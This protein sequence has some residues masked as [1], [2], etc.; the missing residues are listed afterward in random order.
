MKNHDFK[1]EILE[2]LRKLRSLNKAVSTTDRA[3]GITWKD[4]FGNDQT[5]WVDKND[6]LES[7]VEDEFDHLK[8]ELDKLITK[9]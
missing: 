6:H 4:S 9:N 2:D 8:S 5:Y 3:I 1:F 7:F